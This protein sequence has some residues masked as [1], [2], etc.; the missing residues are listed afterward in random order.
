MKKIN[1]WFLIISLI[2]LLTACS[3][4]SMS[5]VAS[6]YRF[7]FV[8]MNPWNGIEGIAFTI[9]YFLHTDKN[10]SMLIGIGL[11]LIMW[12]RLYLLLRRTFGR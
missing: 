9:G 10:T 6:N 11:L 8:A 12:W 1:I 5:S 2:L 7:S 3:I 4:L